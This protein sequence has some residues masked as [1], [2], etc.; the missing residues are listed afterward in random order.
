MLVFCFCLILPL[1][2]PFSLPYTLLL[3]LYQ[4]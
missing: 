1:Y 3:L 4:G 2:C